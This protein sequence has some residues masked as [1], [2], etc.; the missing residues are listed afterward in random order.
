MAG[1]KEELAKKAEQCK[2][3]KSRNLNETE[4]QDDTGKRQEAASPSVC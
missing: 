1:V 3:E 4:E 2:E